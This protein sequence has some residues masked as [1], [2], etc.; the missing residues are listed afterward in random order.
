MNSDEIKQNYSMREVVN[1]YGLTPNRAG[2]VRCPFHKGDRTASM[3]IYKDSFYCFGCG[4]GGDIFYFIQRMDNL[5]FK[6]AFL[7]LG[8][9]YKHE[10]KTFSSMRKIQQAKSQ[11]KKQKQKLVL[12]HHRLDYLS[13]MIEF[14]KKIKLR[15]EPLSDDW[16]E[17]EN[18]LTIL[19]GEYDYL[20]E[21]G[22]K[23]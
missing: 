22:E 3:K 9:E 11:R 4:V 18:K 6:E 21:R 15:S 5:T 20:Q 1:R 10:K 16:C 12:M 8:G 13:L 2:F 7:N 17:A 14:Y 23:I 19:W